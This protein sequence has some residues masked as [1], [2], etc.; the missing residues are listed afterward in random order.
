M[1]LEGGVYGGMGGKLGEMGGKHEGSSHGQGGLVVLTLIFF[2][3]APS[4]YTLL[5][6]KGIMSL[7]SYRVSIQTSIIDSGESYGM[8]FLH[9]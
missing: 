6:L 1:V 8:K 5:S 7:G 2:I 4:K 3:V 9:Y